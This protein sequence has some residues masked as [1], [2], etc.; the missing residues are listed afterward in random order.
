M[1]YPQDFTKPI[2]LLVVGSAD[3]KMEN[4][5]SLLDNLCFDEEGSREIHLYMPFDEHTTGSGLSKVLDWSEARMD[6][7]Q[8]DRKTG[9]IAAEHQLTE[10]MAVTIRSEQEEKYNAIL[11]G[12]NIFMATSGVTEAFVISLYDPAKDLEEIQ[13]IKNTIVGTPIRVLNLCEGLVDSFEGYESP[14]AVAVRE[15]AEK[16]FADQVAE[17]TTKKPAAK[18][19]TTPRKRAEKKVLVP[20]DVPLLP[21]PETAVQTP[22]EPLPVGTVVEVAGIPFVKHSEDIFTDIDRAAQQIVSSDIVQVKKEDLLRLLD[23]LTDIVK[24]M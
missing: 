13:F 11:S 15:K 24:G 18:K 9:I 7:G 2:S 20:E 4:I 17:E 19:A 5:V 1:D 22:S 23:V 14:D 3:S 10:R 6:T 21:E 8:G 16:E 12:L